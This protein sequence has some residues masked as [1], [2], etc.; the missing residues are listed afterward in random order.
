MK[1]IQNMQLIVVVK[2]FLALLHTATL[3]A[4]RGH[5]NDGGKH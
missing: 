1:Q 3:L 4:L 5:L 2:R